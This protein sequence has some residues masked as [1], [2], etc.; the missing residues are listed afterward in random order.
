MQ[1]QSIGPMYNSV[2]GGIQ[3]IAAEEE[4]LNMDR[5]TMETMKALYAAKERA[6]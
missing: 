1:R 2:S 3:H 6:I 4:M 5:S